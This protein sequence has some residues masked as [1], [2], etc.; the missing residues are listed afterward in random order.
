MIFLD[1]KSE[2]PAKK[3]GKCKKKNKFSFSP[4]IEKQTGKKQ[5]K[6][7]EFIRNNKIEKY[8]GRNKKIEKR[9]A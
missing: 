3:N 2:Y 8:H 9:N 6:V 5:Y 7:F 4:G 1:E